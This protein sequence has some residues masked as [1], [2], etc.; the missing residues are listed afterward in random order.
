MFLFIFS[1][2]LVTLNTTDRPK[3]QIFDRGNVRELVVDSY[4]V[5]Y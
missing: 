3:P 2:S 5:S 4:L 1:L